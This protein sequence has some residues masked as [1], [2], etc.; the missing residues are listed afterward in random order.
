LQNIR[1]GHVGDRHGVLF[2][3]TD[4]AEMGDARCALDRARMWCG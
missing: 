2:C 1:V 3:T 4:R